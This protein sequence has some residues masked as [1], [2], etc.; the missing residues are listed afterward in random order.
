MRGRFF[1]PLPQ[2]KGKDG[3]EKV[4]PK[5]L[6]KFIQTGDTYCITAQQWKELGNDMET[7][8][9]TF[10]SAFGEGLRRIDTKY[11]QYKAAEWKIFSLVSP[12]LLI[13]RLHQYHLW[14]YNLLMKAILLACGTELLTEKLVDE[15][16]ENISIFLKWYEKEVYQYKWLRLGAMRSTVHTLTHVSESIY[17]NSPMRGFWEA[18]CEWLVDLMTE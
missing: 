14:H 12:I 9:S 1:L 16:E 5:K 8:R 13:G 2:P 4:P 18:P 3:N 7:S 17:D 10:P 11:Y 15:I 6:P